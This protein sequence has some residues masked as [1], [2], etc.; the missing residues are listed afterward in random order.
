M[1]KF[2]DVYIFFEDCYWIGLQKIKTYL[3]E[4]PTRESYIYQRKAG[5]YEKGEVKEGKLQKETEKMERLWSAASL[6]DDYVRLLQSNRR[7]DYEDMLL[8]VIREFG[9]FEKL[10]RFYQEQYLYLL[11]LDDLARFCSQISMVTCF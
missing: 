4:L 9:R 7:Y 10:L 11:D 6:F 2:C 8:W 3:A 1:Q 5:R